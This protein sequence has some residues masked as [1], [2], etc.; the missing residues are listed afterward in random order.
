[1]SEC[2]HRRIRLADAAKVP[3]FSGKDIFTPTTERT[4]LILS[5]FINFVKFSEQCMPFVTK[6]RGKA[7]DLIQERESVS[8]ERARLEAQL[9]QLKCVLCLC[10][11]QPC[12][13]RSFRA[14][15]AEDEPRLDDIRQ[16]NASITSQLIAYKETQTR[17][18]KDIEY[19]KAEKSS[20]VQKKV[21]YS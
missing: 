20:L 4:R 8:H 15:R 18:L 11:R 16:E 1:M 9:A 14:K 13:K 2:S 7:A 17:L 6:L 10:C 12:L 19:L 21:R 5:A 3:D